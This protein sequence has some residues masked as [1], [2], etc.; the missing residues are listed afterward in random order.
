MGGPVKERSLSFRGVPT[1]RARVTK[2]QVQKSRGECHV[3]SFRCGEARNGPWSCSV[4]TVRHLRHRPIGNQRTQWQLTEDRS[5]R[6]VNE[7]VR[8]SIPGREAFQLS[9]RASRSPVRGRAAPPPPRSGSKVRENGSQQTFTLDYTFEGWRWLP[10]RL[11]LSGVERCPARDEAKH[12]MRSGTISR[13]VHGRGHAWPIN[14][15]PARARFVKDHHHRVRVIIGS[16]RLRPKEGDISPTAVFL[17]NPYAPDALV[18][19]VRTVLP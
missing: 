8:K 7:D 4:Q 1:V 10:L 2:H 16:G 17:P 15:V 12:L 11:R 3:L 19:V 5:R 18:E 6:A 13:A 14:T 9:L